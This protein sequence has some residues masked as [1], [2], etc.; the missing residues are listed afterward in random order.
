MGGNQPYAPSVDETAQDGLSSDTPV[1]GI[2]TMQ[3]FVQ[4][5]KQLAVALARDLH[6]R[7]KSFDLAIE[8]GSTLLDRVV[9]A[10]GR[11][12]LELREHQAFCPHRRSSQCQHGVD[13]HRSEQSCFPRHVR[14]AD[15]HRSALAI[16]THR[17][18]HAIRLNQQWMSDLFTLKIGTTIANLGERVRRML[19]GVAGQVTQRFQLTDGIEPESNLGAVLSTP[20]LDR[21]AKVHAP[22]QQI[23]KGR[24]EL[25]SLCVEPRNA[26]LER[27]NT[28]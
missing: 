27:R 8:A 22:H 18:A 13:A 2:G 17:I 5:E 28:H 25:V 6:E 24:K 11:T 14:T 23:R 3:D 16:E 7:L 1:V 4:Q 21:Q 19:E 9:D 10:N 26:A 12:D 20:T 15:D